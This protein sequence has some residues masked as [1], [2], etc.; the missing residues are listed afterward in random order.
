MIESLK[1]NEF[2]LFN[3][4]DIE[5]YKGLNVLTGETGSGKSLII[6]AIKFITDDIKIE[7]SEKTIVEITIKE[8]NNNA[9]DFLKQNDFID[10]E[11]NVTIKKESFKNKPSKYYINEYK[12]NKKLVK[13]LLSLVIVF[14]DQNSKSIIEKDSFFYKKRRYSFFILYSSLAKCVLTNL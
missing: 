4:L 5:F 10:S 11:N 13:E 1:L 8:L 2:I 12:A 7:P 9:I 6:K 3:S 14:V